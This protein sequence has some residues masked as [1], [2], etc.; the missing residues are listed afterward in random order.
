M[1]WSRINA[2]VH[3]DVLVERLCAAME[4]RAKLAYGNAR[5]NKTKQHLNCA[6]ESAGDPRVESLLENSYIALATLR[7]PG[8]PLEDTLSLPYAV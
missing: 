6:Q 7:Q 3:T 4:A 1:E 5:K 8:H 2:N